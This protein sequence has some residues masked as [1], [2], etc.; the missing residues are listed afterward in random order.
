MRSRLLSFPVRF[1]GKPPK[2]APAPLLGQ[3]TTEVFGNWLG[4]SERDIGG[5]KDDGVV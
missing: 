3:H 5:L 1:D 2:I 4:L